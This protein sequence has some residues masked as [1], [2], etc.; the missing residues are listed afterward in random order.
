ML[1]DA[2]ANW[3]SQLQERDLDA[4]FTEL[5]RSLRFYDIHFTHGG[6]EFGKDFIAKRNEPQPTQY[7]F[8]SKAGDIGGAAWAEM[9]SQLD[10]L[11][12]AGPAHPSF[13]RSLPRK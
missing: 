13:D 9:F 5:L 3:I 7:G 10:E 4:P 11:A 12:N 1:A 8:Q 6:Y 2:F